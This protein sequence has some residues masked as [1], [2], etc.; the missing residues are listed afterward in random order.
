MVVFE[1]SVVLIALVPWP[2]AYNQFSLVMVWHQSVAIFFLS[3]PWLIATGLASRK[4][5]AAL[6]LSQRIN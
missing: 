4:L 3:L 2:I 5:A 1:V 6:G